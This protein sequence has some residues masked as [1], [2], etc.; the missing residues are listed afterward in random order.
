METKV[1][2]KQ[3]VFKAYDQNQYVKVP[4]DIGSFIPAGHIVRII[5][6]VVET[7]D[8][9]VLESYYV[10]GGSS[11]Y[12]PKMLIKVW[13]YGYC[14]RVYTSRPLSKA[15]NEQLP[16]MWLA[17]GQLPCF[18]TLSEFRGCRMQGMIDIIFKQV[19]LILLEWG[20]ITLDD[21][22]V[23]GS[24]IE[25]NANQHKVVWAKNTERYKAGVIEHIDALLAQVKILQESEDVFYGAHHLPS[26][27]R[28]TDVQ[29]VLN[30]EQVRTHLTNMNTFVEQAVKNM[31]ETSD[32]KEILDLKIQL[33]KVNKLVRDLEK[34]HTKLVKYEQQEE[35]LA[36]RNSYSKTDEDA[37]MLRLK[38]EQLLP[39]Y[40]I[41]HSTNNQ[42]ITNYTIEQTAGDSTT[43]PEHLD[44]LEQ[45]LTDIPSEYKEYQPNKK[46][47]IAD[48]GYGSEQNY[49]DLEKRGLEAFVKY[50]LFHQEQTGEILKS[51]FRRENFP[52]DNT[53]D[54]FTCPN[55]RK[56]VFSHLQTVTSANG[57][58]RELRVYSC[59]N[60][61]D[62]PFAAECKK[63]EH[64][65]R[66]VQVSPK[67]EAY[68][69]QAKE[70]L[71]SE[72]GVK[73]RKQRS[74]EVETA[75]ADIKYNMKYE[76]FIL[77]SLDKVYVEYGLL[78]IAHNLRKVYCE[79][80]GIW[81][82]YYAQRAA[83]K[84]NSTQKRA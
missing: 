84:T 29:I 50:P 37:T 31:K 35:I 64:K 58:P 23:D 18:K 19:L 48:A 44:K 60:C 39:A 75:F 82:D 42:Y 10:G 4:I 27:E 46:H 36:G 40:N 79:Q 56:L 6:E 24:K 33:K 32:K 69:A 41:Q 59:E 76:R 54:S 34:E 30:S 8:I 3:I 72:Q 53:T 2:K 15:L 47:L 67:G 43:L 16:F 5:N 61:Q 55:N 70:K 1:I 49:A 62:C 52:Y 80:S 77:R 45:R 78:A 25:A 14:S 7:L 65:E 21:I 68:K 71:L 57:Y 66:S 13:V 38:D 81:A 17:G 9:G 20:Y 51:K 28:D 22:Y 74:I 73:F 12:H 83:N 26:M 11:S 63:S